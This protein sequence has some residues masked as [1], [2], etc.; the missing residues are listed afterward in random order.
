MAPYVESEGAVITYP[1]LAVS[2]LAGDSE[3][4]HAGSYR[5]ART[6]LQDV[7]S[8]IMTPGDVENPICTP[9]IVSVAT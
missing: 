5:T 8:Q 9:D 2:V 4:A 3:A 6:T 1:G 7:L